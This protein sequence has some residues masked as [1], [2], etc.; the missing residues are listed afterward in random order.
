MWLT[1][2]SRMA[3][4]SAI[5]EHARDIAS[6]ARL[7]KRLMKQ[8]TNHNIIVI[9]GGPAG[10][11]AATLLARDGH[12]VLLLEREKFPREHVGESLLPFCYS[13]FKNLGVVEE[14]K[15]SFVRK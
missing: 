10:S 8:E 2:A 9:G 11:T 14:M 15:K 13:L 7:L 12:S 5:A 1:L 6:S 3:S 4:I